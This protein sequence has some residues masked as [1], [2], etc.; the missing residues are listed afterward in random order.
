MQLT[1]SFRSRGKRIGWWRCC[2]TIFKMSARPPNRFTSLSSDLLNE[3]GV[4]DND[5][6]LPPLD[7]PESCLDSD[8]TPISTRRLRLPALTTFLGLESSPLR[9]PTRRIHRHQE[10]SSSVP[11]IAPAPAAADLDVRASDDIMFTPR[12][13]KRVLTQRAQQK[14][15]VTLGQKSKLSCLKTHI[16]C[17]DIT[18]SKQTRN[19][20]D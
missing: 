17:T 14:R 4:M 7:E 11:P 20:P 3:D 9:G 15:R 10:R 19:R 16:M 6:A 2:G 8:T 12:T 1:S 5:D 18:C 13:E